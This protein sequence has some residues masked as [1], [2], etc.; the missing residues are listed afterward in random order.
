MDRV[1][2]GQAIRARRTALGWSQQ[3]LADELAAAEGR[4]RGGLDRGA[5]YRWEHGTRLPGYWMPYLD[6]VLA[7]S[8]PRSPGTNPLPG[9]PPLL[10]DTVASALA[11]GEWDMDW[12]RRHLLRASGAFALSVLDLPDAPDPDAVERRTRAAQAGATVRVGRGEVDA[13]GQMTVSLGDAAAELGGAH[14][15]SLAVTYLT[16]TVMPW[17]EQGAYGDA[18]GRD[19]LASTSG[20]CH[21]CGWMAGDEGNEGVAQRYYAE[22]Y[23][24]A[25]RAGAAEL[26]ATALRGMAVQMIELGQ[27]AAAVR[28]AEQCAAYAGR[29]EDPRAAAYYQATLAQAAALDGDARGAVAALS[30]SQRAI[31]RAPSAPGRSWAAHYSPGRWAHESGLILARL[32]DG[33]AA[34]EHLH[35]ALEIYGLDRRRT[36]AMVLA[37]LGQVL[38]RRGDTDGA[39][40]AFSQFL[41]AAAGVRSVKITE[42]VTGMRAR[43]GRFGRTGA[44]QNLNERAATLETA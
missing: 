14:A 21:L 41:D 23:R 34:E 6:C 44:V 30:A 20:L 9:P 3:R 42:A 8:A 35:L 28:L 1:L 26:A 32:G 4:G 10:G 31:E 12:K 18:T 11:L 15:R 7:L 17:I 39:L 16:G 43:L 33:Q 38:A 37:D 24:M 25:E 27:A 19:L 22:A 2:I 36:R 13:I 29:V 5:V 40:T